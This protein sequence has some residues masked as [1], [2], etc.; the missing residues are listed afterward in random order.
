MNSASEWRSGWIERTYYIVA[1]F[2]KLLKFTL[3]FRSASSSSAI[4]QISKSSLDWWGEDEISSS[5]EF[6]H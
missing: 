4:S 5:K 1:V 3:G 6:A 2:R